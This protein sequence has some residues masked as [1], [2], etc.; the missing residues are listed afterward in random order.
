MKKAAR[1][2]F[3]AAFK[4]GIWWCSRPV[5]SL[6]A[7]GNRPLGMVCKSQPRDGLI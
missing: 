1:R 2:L 3:L 5:K 6:A 7:K 4:L